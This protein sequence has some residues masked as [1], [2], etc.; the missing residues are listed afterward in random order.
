MAMEASQK[1]P[2]H[3]QPFGRY[4]FAAL[5][6]TVCTAIQRLRKE[7]ALATGLRSRRRC[8]GGPARLLRRQSSAP[9]WRWM[10]SSSVT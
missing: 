10:Q 5:L 1:R 8:S 6:R 7:Q 4:N 2:K 9:E 3:V